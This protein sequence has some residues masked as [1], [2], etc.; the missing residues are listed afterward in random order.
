M[1]AAPAAALLVVLAGLPGAGKTG[2]AALLQE[3]AQEHAVAIRRLCLDEL[4]QSASGAGA[5][6]PDAWQASRR[7][8]VQA[9][10]DALAQHARARPQQQAPQQRQL[11]VVVDDVHHLRSMR[12]ELAQLARAHAAAFMQVFLDCPLELALQR[13]RARVG[14]ERVPDAV[15]ARLATAFEPPAAD[16]RA[17]EAQ[18]TLTLAAG[19]AALEPAWLWAQVLR[20]WG[21]PLPAPPSEQELAARREAGTAANAASAAHGFDLRT[22]SALSAALAHLPPDGRAAAAARLNAARKQLLGRLRAAPGDGELAQE[23]LD[24]FAAE[25]AGVG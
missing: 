24:A 11:V 2:V 20:H 13:N 22:R 4:Q 21:G 25:C 16:A 9:A 23:L 19:G 14:A 3:A 12:H 6:S 8:L 15:L 10:G 1:A 5:F 18:H 7:Q 17:W